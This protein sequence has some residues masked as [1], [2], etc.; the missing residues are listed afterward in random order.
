MMLRLKLWA[1][2][3]L[4]ALA[5]ALGIYAKG[6]ADAKAKAAVKDLKE[7]IA[8]HD[9]LNKAETGADLDDAGRAAWLRAFAKRNRD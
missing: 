1:A 9:R 6:R 4:A 8:T 5:A 7:E 2:A 3:F